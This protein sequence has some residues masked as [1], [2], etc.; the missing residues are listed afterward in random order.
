LE[1][2][3]ATRV[4]ARSDPR[5]DPRSGQ[6]TAPAT[7]TISRLRQGVVAEVLFAAVVLGLTAILVEAAPA[8]AVSAATRSAATA[9]QPAAGSA[10]P[11][12]T[13]A[14]HAHGPGQ[15]APLQHTTVGFDTGG[16]N[17]TGKLTAFVDPASVGPNTLY[18]E[19]LGNDGRFRQVPEVDAAFS[20][21]AR[22]LGPLRTALDR[23]GAGR[24][25]NNQVILPIPGRWLLTIT[26]RT[27]AFD[28]T[29]VTLPVQIGSF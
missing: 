6:R 9:G 27:S 1:R 7:A 11:A 22:R 4:L 15:H 28:E 16:P 23:A 3:L 10:P 25:I 14:G 26:V 29:A 5:S 8:T 20:L 13:H 24:Y 2:N 18:I 17:G 21:P 12:S 19:V